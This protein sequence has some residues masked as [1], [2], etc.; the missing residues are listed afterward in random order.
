MWCCTDWSQLYNVL[1]MIAAIDAFDLHACC[2]LLQS[3]N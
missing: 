2:L 3:L 1:G